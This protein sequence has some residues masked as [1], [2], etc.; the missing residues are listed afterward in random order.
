MKKY[1]ARV[2]KEIA[3]R[4]A[5]EGE[6]ATQDALTWCVNKLSEGGYTDAAL[7]LVQEINTD[8]TTAPSK[9]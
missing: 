7:W 9:G 8:E 5:E 6:Q 2:Q 3:E 1:H 4:I